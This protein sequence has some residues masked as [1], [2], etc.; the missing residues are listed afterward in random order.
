MYA[1]IFYEAHV[2]TGGYFLDN[3]G[4]LWEQNPDAPYKKKSFT[5]EAV[6]NFYWVF[7]ALN[8]PDEERAIVE[9]SNLWGSLIYNPDPKITQTE[10]P[11]STK[12]ISQVTPKGLIQATQMQIEAKQSPLALIV[13][14]RLE[15]HDYEG[16]SVPH[17]MPANLAVAITLGAKFRPAKLKYTTCKYYLLKKRERNRAYGKCPLG[18][19]I[20]SKGGRKEWGKG[21]KDYYKAMQ[22]AAKAKKDSVMNT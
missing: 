6:Q 17:I 3:E 15:Y 10:K 13:G 19:Q 16:R 2:N 11:L 12:T 22:R 9:F 7:E 8:K 4:Y 21:C 20:D 1:P 14:R 18:C 5:Y